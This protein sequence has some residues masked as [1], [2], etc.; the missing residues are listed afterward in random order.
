M[1][2]FFLKVKQNVKAYRE[3]L[4]DNSA[5]NIKEW[6]EIPL[7]DKANYLLK[8]PIEDLAFDDISKA[9]LIGTSS[10]FSKSGAVFWLKEA[11]DES[12]YLETVK[13]I[14][15]DE[16]EI[17]KNKTL[18]VI[19]L[20][21][22]TWIGGM[23][24]ATTLRSLAASM[25]GVTITTPS[26]DLNEASLI[27]KKFGKYYDKIIWVC[28][29]SSINIIYSLIKDDDSLLQKK[30]AFPVV[31]EYFSEDFREEIALK[32]GYQKE[33]A[34]SIKTGYGSADAGDLGI[35]S[36]HTIELRKF[37]NRNLELAK[38]V[39][40]KKEAPMMF[41]KNPHAFIE[42]HDGN[43]IVTKEQFI[44]LVRYNTKDCGNILRKD[45]IKHLIPES[46][47]QNLPDEILYIFGRANDS[48]IF[49]GTNIDID[50]IKKFLSS[51]KNMSYGGLFEIEEIKEK[52]IS[53]FEFTIYVDEIDENL[54]LIYK[55]ELIEFLK[56]SSNEFNAKY[57]KLSNAAGRELINVVLKEISKLTIDKKH[58][59]IKG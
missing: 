7:C 55:K 24:I 11:T 30:I 31:G 51:L 20:A 2:E 18:F 32:L 39:F 43:L 35:E 52:D 4:E 16:Y 10:G 6:S 28:N 5:N 12:A 49:Y 37:F 29:P 36:E 47:Y 3:F 46:L 1:Y 8:Y 38:T 54:K 45:S 57:E 53:C 15:I 41:V 19:S 34:F 40:N 56:R 58:R 27:V 26:L 13:K 17:D 50:Q 33:Y 9:F 44:P 14:F 23:Q 21:F 22:G 42:C 25:E 48:V 59:Y